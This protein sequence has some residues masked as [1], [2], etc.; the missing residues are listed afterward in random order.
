MLDKIV[1]DL[2]SDLYTQ[3]ETH[4]LSVKIS[5]Y[6]GNTLTIKSNGLYAQA[7]KGVDGSVGEGYTKQQQEGTRVGYAGPFELTSDNLVDGRAC[8]TNIAHRVFT[9]NNKDGSSLDG[10]RSEVDYVL[11]GDLYRVPNGEQYDYYLVTRTSSDSGGAPGNVV[12]SSE[13]LGTWG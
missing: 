11:V 3:A 5:E 4:Q 9:T 8:V 7:S 13:F 2:D 6:Q 10:F 1:L 12:K